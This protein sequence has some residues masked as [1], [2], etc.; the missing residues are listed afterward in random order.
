VFET[1]VVFQGLRLS[2]IGVAR[3]GRCGI[4]AD[5]NNFQHVIC[6]KAWDPLVFVDRPIVLIAVW[7]LSQSGCRH[8]ARAGSIPSTHYGTNRSIWI[9][10]RN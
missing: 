10:P 6:V 5:E 8:F 9:P 3:L 1:W 7:R 2:V 4:R